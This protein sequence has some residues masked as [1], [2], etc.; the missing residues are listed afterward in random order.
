MK[1]RNLIC[2]ML[3]VLLA[4]GVGGCSYRQME[5]VAKQKIQE[6]VIGETEAD[7]GKEV[8]EINSAEDNIYKKG[9]TI[10]WRDY[11][12]QQIQY[13]L[14]DV[15]MAENINDFGVP[16]EEFTTGAQ[17]FL[18]PDGSLVDGENGKNILVK[19]TVDIKNIDYEGFPDETD[20]DY[21]LYAETLILTQ[22]E[23]ENADGIAHNMQAA[24]FSQHSHGEKDYYFYTLEAGT[25]TTAELI[26]IV[27]E[28][29]LQ[30]P[31]YYII[32]EASGRD[33][34]QLFRLNE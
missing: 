7:V 12:G 17:S 2:G 4:M 30:E 31:L 8:V 33:A 16:P 32:G 24:Y 15:Q 28:N 34:F 26:W 14:K 5:D 1:R 9:E 10:V 6:E 27:P 21:L 19:A 13:T 22:T 23:L 3:A 11:S 18:S 20:T 29:D 25:E